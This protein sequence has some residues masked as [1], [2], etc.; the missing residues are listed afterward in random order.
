M[1]K[2]LKKFALFGLPGSGKSTF[3]DQLGKKLGLPVH[4]LDRHYFLAHWEIRPRDQF[5]AAQQEM[6]DGDAWV[7]EGN[8]IATLEMRFQR[9]DVILYFNL[10]RYLCLWRV[11]KRPFHHDKT[12]KDIPE[13]CSKS[14]ISWSLLKYLWHFDAEKRAHIEELKK[15]YPLV[16]FREIKS[17]KEAVQFLKE[18][19]NASV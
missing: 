4:H 2:D 15:K 11:F 16:D 3:A 13:G 9:A 17:A 19:E 10:P 5:L 14:D 7:I 6:V 18:C 1:K 8:S 12:I